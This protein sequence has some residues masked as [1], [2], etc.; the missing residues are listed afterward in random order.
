MRA[1]AAAEVA[2]VPGGE[3]AGVGR[4]LGG[5]GVVITGFD[6]VVVVPGR[7]SVV[8]ECFLECWRGRWPGLRVAVDTDET[9]AEFSPWL[10]GRHRLPDGPA[11]VLVSRDAGMEEFW[12]AEGYALDGKREGPV[13]FFYQLARWRALKLTTLEDPYP[14][15]GCRHEPYPVTLAG[16]EFSLVTI[17]TPDEES[18]FSRSVLDAFLKCCAATSGNGGKS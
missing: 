12:D 1:G 5:G 3:G 9:G 11:D 17:V 15:E 13:A 16:A 2:A 10:P 14:Y 8:V 18:D 7:A 4:R 6:R